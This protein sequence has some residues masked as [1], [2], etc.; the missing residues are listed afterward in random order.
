[1]KISGIDQQCPVR[2][3]LMLFLSYPNAFIGYLKGQ[4]KLDFR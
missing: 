2:F 3:L 4:F 1:V